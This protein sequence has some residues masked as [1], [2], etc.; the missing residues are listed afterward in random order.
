[1]LLLD[2]G[3]GVGVGV[4]D[5]FVAIVVVLGRLL[6]GLLEFLRVKTELVQL[7]Y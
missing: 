6:L 1:M 4:V 2:D 3:G 5:V 7:H